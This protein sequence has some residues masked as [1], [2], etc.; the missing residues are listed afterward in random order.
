M[1]DGGLERVLDVAVAP[2]SSSQCCMMCTS[3]AIASTT[4]SGTSMLASTL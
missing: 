2:R 4:M 3:S 1:R